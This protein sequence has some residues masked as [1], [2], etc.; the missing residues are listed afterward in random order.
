MMKKT[1]KAMVCNRINMVYRL[2]TTSMVC[3]GMSALL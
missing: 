2:K 1:L 3:K